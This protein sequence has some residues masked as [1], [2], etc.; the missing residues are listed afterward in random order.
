MAKKPFTSSP[1]NGDEHEDADHDGLPRDDVADH[2]EG[3]D[4]GLPA[5]RAGDV[6]SPPQ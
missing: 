4:G 6:I 1:E 3:I 5:L 2:F